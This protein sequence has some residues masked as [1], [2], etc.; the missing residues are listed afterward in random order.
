MNN[1]LVYD[2]AVNQLLARLVTPSSRKNVKLLSVELPFCGLK[3]WMRFCHF[4]TNE[5]LRKKGAIGRN[6]FAVQS[7]NYLSILSL[8]EFVS[9]YMDFAGKT[10]IFRH[11]VHMY[12]I[13]TIHSLSSI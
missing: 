9:L 3:K 6:V 2:N 8:S 12:S 11:L 13:S 5:K 1:H 4:F 7:R 10:N